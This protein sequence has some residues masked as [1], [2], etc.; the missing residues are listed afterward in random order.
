MLGV[1]TR[2]RSREREAVITVR[3]RLT[4]IL[5]GGEC[6]RTL[7]RVRLTI[8]SEEIDATELSDEDAC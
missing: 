8:R 2:Q 1:V 4:G 3:P 7:R 6:A 5:V